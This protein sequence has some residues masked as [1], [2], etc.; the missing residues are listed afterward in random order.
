M[1]RFSDVAGL[2]SLGWAVLLGWA[3][4]VRPVPPV[5]L[6]LV[7]VSVLALAL[8]VQV[9]RSFGAD[10]PAAARR[11]VALALGT[12]VSALLVVWVVLTVLF[13]PGPEQPQH[14]VVADAGIVNGQALTLGAT[15]V[16][17]VLRPR[18]AQLQIRAAV[19]GCVLATV[20]ALGYTAVT[21]PF[22]RVLGLAAVASPLIGWN[23]PVCLVI[24]LLLVLLRGYRNGRP[25]AAAGLLLVAV[26]AWAG[27]VIPVEVV[28]VLHSGAPAVLSPFDPQWA[29]GPI[30][31]AGALLAVPVTGR[32]RRSSQRVRVRMLGG[33]CI[34][35]GILVLA[36][37]GTAAARFIWLGTLSAP[38]GLPV[39]RDVLLLM[40]AGAVLLITA[41]QW[42][43]RHGPVTGVVVLGV[44]LVC[45][46]AGLLAF[47]VVVRGGNRSWNGV[48]LALVLVL[49]LIVATLTV[50]AQ[51][52]RAGAGTAASLPR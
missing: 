45:L 41:G 44:V 39:A 51:R 22:N 28:R 8:A 35:L 26:V 31:V 27:L 30:A 7:A 34:T 9:V 46:S 15:A 38:E 11:G 3:G 40:L 23:V 24:G 43:I 33:S 32:Y 14:W 25:W 13:R 20:L 1:K 17:L 29:L 21:D 18:M 12:V 47:D 6:V 5:T 10:D 36:L 50:Q 37:L 16:A 4:R 48:Q 52:A 49:P 2:F 19:T 42:Q